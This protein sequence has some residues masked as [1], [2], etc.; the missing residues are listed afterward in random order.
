MMPEQLW[1]TTLNPATRK[2]KRLTMEDA[3]EASHLFTLLMGDRVEPR[4]A[5]IEAHGSRF[6]LQDL[7]I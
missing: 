4:R 5:L 6:R 1:Q 7:D 3:A 2:L